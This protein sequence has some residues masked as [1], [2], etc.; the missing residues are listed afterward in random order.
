MRAKDEQ[1]Q[2]SVLVALANSALQQSAQ[3][4]ANQPS[5]AK[6]LTWAAFSRDLPSSGGRGGQWKAFEDLPSK[7]QNGCVLLQDNNSL[8]VAF[9][10]R[11]GISAEHYWDKS[12]L[13]SR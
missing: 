4:I 8:D 5:S 9:V 7:F 2:Q 12:T 6:C 13:S 3:A 10:L 1:S 11:Q